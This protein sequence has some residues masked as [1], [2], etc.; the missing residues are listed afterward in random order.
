MINGSDV[1]IAQAAAFSYYC[2]HCPP[3]PVQGSRSAVTVK[4]DIK[5]ANDKCSLRAINE[6]KTDIFF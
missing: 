3:K 1:P 5:F 2:N 4:T 6:V